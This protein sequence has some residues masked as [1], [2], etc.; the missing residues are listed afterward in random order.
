MTGL[1]ALGFFRKDITFLEDI[2][3]ISYENIFRMYLNED[4]SGN[5]FLYYNL[6]NSVYFPKNLSSNM[7]YTIEINRILPWTAISY[8]E[9]RTTDLWWVIVLT[10]NIFNP[11]YFPKPGTKLK[12][13]KP[14]Y[15]K[16]LLSEITNQLKTQ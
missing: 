12:I 1:S 15:I 11:I 10:N 3:N 2:P 13:I 6:I 16:I 9:Y 7:F 14:E 8:N 4:A 5:K